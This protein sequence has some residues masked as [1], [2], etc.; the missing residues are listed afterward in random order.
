ME[1]AAALSKVVPLV[2]ALLLA[3]VAAACSQEPEQ[4]EAVSQC[5]KSLF[6]SYN[7]R[8][9]DQCISACVQCK[10]GVVTTC[11]TSCSLK[12]AK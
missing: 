4:T 1:R 8:D 9:K 12:G 3:C 6:P 10:R 11:A 5:I 7:P 2:A